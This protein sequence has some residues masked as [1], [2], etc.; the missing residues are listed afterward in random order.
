MKTLSPSPCGCL[1][2][3]PLHSTA[4]ELLNVCKEI[5]MNENIIMASM[6]LGPGQKI[7]E[8]LKKVLVIIEKAERGV[9]R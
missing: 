1:L 5:I 8:T 2:E 3:C 6:A 4:E 9:S 7:F